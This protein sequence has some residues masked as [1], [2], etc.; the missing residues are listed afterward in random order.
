MIT[1]RFFISGIVTTAAAVTASQFLPVEWP[2]PYAT[3]YGV[4]WDL[5]VV[6]YDVWTEQDALKFAKFGVGG[7]DQFREITDIVYN[8]PMEPLPVNINRNFRTDPVDPLDRF[9][10]NLS[11]GFFTNMEGREWDGKSTKY[12]T[13]SLEERKRYYRD[14]NDIWYFDRLAK[15]NEAIKA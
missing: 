9:R 13:V 10:W 14:E 3:V 5:E 6:E 12:W 1:K 7:I 2:K 11:P 15:E 8:V 4:G